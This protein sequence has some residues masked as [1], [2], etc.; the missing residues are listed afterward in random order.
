MKRTLVSLANESITPTTVGG[1]KV[2]AGL[3]KIKHSFLS[4]SEEGIFDVFKK[5][6]AEKKYVTGD[7]AKIIKEAAGAQT[8]ALHLKGV[9]ARTGDFKT[10]MQFLEELEGL[11]GQ[12]EKYTAHCVEQYVAYSLAFKNQINASAA[13]V[14]SAAQAA[15]RMNKPRLS[16]FSGLKAVNDKPGTYQSSTGLLLVSPLNNTVNPPF[17]DTD[18]L[19]VLKHCAEDIQYFVGIQYPKIQE[20]APESALTLEP[21]QSKQFL[22]K[23]LT[24][25]EKAERQFQHWDDDA[26]LK[27]VVSTIEKLFRLFDEYDYDSAEEHAYYFVEEYHQGN[28]T[29]LATDL[30]Y[31][32]DALLEHVSKSL[33]K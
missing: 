22:T 13:A 32:V 17:K 3:L 28:V 24:V 2:N 25:W 10:C 29:W 15:D 20:G 23:L 7:G 4:I 21:E 9:L 18:P 14:I 8:A 26:K 11:I 1:R 16:F 5:K 12:A 27:D 30:Y 6:E 19:K 33:S 31:T